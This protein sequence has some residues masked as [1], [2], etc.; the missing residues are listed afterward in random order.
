MIQIKIVI[1]CL[2]LA[3]LCGRANPQELRDVYRRVREAVVPIHTE[4]REPHR[5]HGE[6]LLRVRVP[7]CW[8]REMARS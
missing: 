8:F 2:F 4:E 5:M 1:T 7:A 6:R 3:G